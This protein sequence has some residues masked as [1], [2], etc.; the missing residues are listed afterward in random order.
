LTNLDA[1]PTDAGE[2]PT[3]PPT[4]QV[5]TIHLQKLPLLAGVDEAAL[6]KVAGALQVRKA[7]RG[8]TI[9]NKGGA[10]DYLLFLL[11]GRLQAVDITEDGREVG[12]SFLVPGDYFG[13]LSVIDELPRSA[14]VVACE[15]SIYALLPRLHAL[16]L[17]HNNPLIAER[18]FKRLAVGIRR[19][20]NFRTILGIPAAFQRVYALLDYL[21]Q[22]GPG[23]LVVI[24]RLPTQQEISIMINTSRET[25]SRAIQVLIQRGV[26]EKDLKRLI[27]RQPEALREE[28]GLIKPPRDEPKP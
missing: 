28:L 15:P 4:E 5:Y 9:L 6:K 21:S 23:G 20:S 19:A 13:E 8:Q 7:E 1:T 12:L 10:G 22:K 24:E 3:L 26:V 14:T 2:A 11:S 25:V 18:M 16:D 27:I 17:M